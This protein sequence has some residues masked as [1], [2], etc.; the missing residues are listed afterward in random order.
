MK[1]RFT[2]LFI[3]LILLGQSLSAQII[4]TVAGGGTNYH[5]G[6]A[7][8]AHLDGPTSVAVDARANIYISC[9]YGDI[10][11]TGII[12]KVDGSGIITTIAGNGSAGFTGDGGAATSAGL[13][14]PRGLA[15][16]AVGSVY[17]VDAAIY[18]VRKISTSGVITTIA[19]TG[20][21]GYNGDGIPATDAQLYNPAGVAV[22]WSGNKYITDPGSSRIRKI[23][24]H[25]IISTIAGNGTRGYSGDGGPATAA[26]LKG[27]NGIAVDGSGNVYFSEWGNYS[28][29]KIS[30]MGIITT[31]AGTGTR[32]YN[33]DGI[34]ATMA[35]LND[36][37]GVSV[38]DVGNV[39]IADASNYRI[40]KV[41]TSGIIST[42]AGTGV[43]GFSGDGGA[44][45]LAELSTSGLTYASGKIYFCDGYR[46]GR[47]RVITPSSV[48]V[49]PVPT[50]PVGISVYPNPT[51]GH[52]RANLTSTTDE[53]VKM[54]IMDMAGRKIKEVNAKTNTPTDI[55]FNVPPGVYT[56]IVV[57]E[58]EKI[59]EK[60]IVR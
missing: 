52:F 48:F 33:G 6:P 12:R 30:P 1:S 34:A 54:V 31:I 4:T 47:I 43:P 60:V 45:I 7:T 50:V 9:I 58:S 11:S 55:Q 42:I 19:G 38:D 16:D 59:C 23:D 32:G 25:G 3:S 41:N 39:Y 51:H 5:D 18:R 15:I 24:R 8:A 49:D 28:V 13:A 44:A 27:P 40:R 21:Y 17:F 22:D 56:L 35:Q 37:A 10:T 57:T 36:P 46:D 14:T 29:R 20:T 2:L 26:Q 53:Q